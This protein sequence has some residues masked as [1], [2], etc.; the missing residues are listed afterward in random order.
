MPD[1][2]LEEMLLRLFSPR[3]FPT[4]LPDDPARL[5]AIMQEWSI[6]ESL[7]RQG[8]GHLFDPDDPDFFDKQRNEP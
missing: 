2:E 5:K 6:I 3:P 1:I 8:Y 4:S 7:I